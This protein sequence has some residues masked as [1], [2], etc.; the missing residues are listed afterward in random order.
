MTNV[1]KSNERR[2]AALRDTPVD[3]KV[4]LSGLWI[5]MLFVFAYV[6]IFGFWREDVINGALSGKVPGPGFEINQMFLALT[7]LYIVIPSLMVVVSLIAP[8]RINRRVNL[9]VSI[10]YI[11]T[12]IGAAVGESWVYYLIGSAVEVVLLAA[13]ARIA[14]TWPS[15]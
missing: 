9:V 5:A 6:D 12:V 11:V 3:I 10:V 7:T 8:A 1:T 15:R 14:W 2:T 4:V 13:I